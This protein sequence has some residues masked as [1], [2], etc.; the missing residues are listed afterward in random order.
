MVCIIFNDSLE[1]ALTNKGNPLGL[2]YKLNFS[3]PFKTSS[4]ISNIFTTISKASGGGDANNIG[5]NYVDG[6]MFANDYEWFTYGGLLQVTDAFPTQDGDKVAAYQQ[7]P[8]GPEKQFSASYIVEDLPDGITRYVTYGAAVSA[9]SE[10]LGFYF[11]GL[12]S[13]VFG[14]ILQ[15]PGRNASLN[16]DT[17]SMTMI[18]LNMTTQ[19]SEVWKNDTLHPSVPGRASPELVWLPISKN[20]ILVAIGGAV[21]PSYANLN[22][23]NNATLNA[24]S[25][26]WL[27]IAL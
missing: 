10:N 19:G 1:Q 17:N 13:S 23:T 4:N 12:R 6:G 2:V 27:T 5:P 20:G 11:G 15:S 9:P 26:S 21:F 18:Q 16:A 14:E 22:R 7:Y 24:E 8:S 3:Q 25:V